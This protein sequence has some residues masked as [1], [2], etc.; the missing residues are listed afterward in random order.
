MSWIRPIIKCSKCGSTRYGYTDDM[1]LL[2][3]KCGH[4]DGKRKDDWRTSED[5]KTYVYKHEAIRKF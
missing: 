4:T 2:C 1:R 3:R 5:T